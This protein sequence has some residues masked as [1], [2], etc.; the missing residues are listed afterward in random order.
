MADAPAPS[1]AAALCA[2][3]L[4]HHRA[5]QTGEAEALYRQALDQDPNHAGACHG[6]GVLA[7][8][9]GRLEEAI[10]LLTRAV[11]GRSDV[12]EYHTNLGN[13]LHDAGRHEAAA[14][15]HRQA[16]S[17]NPGFAL[18]WNNLGNALWALGR[19]DEA[20]EALRTAVSLDPRS[21]EGLTNLGNGLRDTGRSDE[22]VAAQRAAIALQ[23]DRAELH[24]N[25]GNTL[26]LRGELD[27]AIPCYRRAIA[28]RS[29]SPAMHSQLILTLAYHP[30]CTEQA[31]RDELA[32]WNAR[33]AEPLRP[34]IQP[35]TNDRDPD[36]RLR[37]GY[38]SSFFRTHVCATFLEPLL[39]HHDRNAV[40]IC[41]YSTVTDPDARTARFKTL[42]AHWRD[43][44]RLSDD[45][46]AALIRRDRIDVLVDL[47]L[48]TAENRLP[49]FARKPAPVQLTWL[50]YPG[51][52]GMPA[53]DYR[54]TDAYLDPPGADESAYAERTVRLRTFWCYGPDG[55]EPPVSPPP[56]LA[57][58]HVTF[59]CLN[60][61]CKVNEQV[62]ALWSAVLARARGAR[63]LILCD[64]GSHRDRAIAS[65]ASRGIEP[66]RVTFE[67]R[68]PRRE[69]LALYNQLDVALDTFPYAGHTTTLD[70]IWMGV[71]VVTLPGRSIVSRGGAGILAHVDLPELIARDAD[72]YVRVATDLATNPSRLA[73]CRATL[74]ARMAASAVTNAPA[75]ARAFEGALRD[76]WQAWCSA[77]QLPV[78]GRPR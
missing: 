22:A 36:R 47:H 72:D 35:H 64:P 1:A 8:R 63:L 19:R 44:A 77:A 75:F 42:A 26:A 16:L 29:D 67:P 25:L 57:N 53:I 49:V 78:R 52:T 58:G 60:N 11:A 4:R 32:R 5:G 28:L 21:A 54:L 43:V 71:P 51:S 40:E 61:F 70:A 23:P 9:T 73:A 18:A 14:A 13:A 56:F 17:L 59:G 34:L 41:C 39:A 7:R 31:M 69:Y 33:H 65:L 30:A 46:L 66:S 10:D 76:A 2:A 15:A 55:T 38:V 6:L 50:G 74:R 12:A 3:A 62:L 20:V 45:R 24:L 37:V 48:H 27:E 68:R